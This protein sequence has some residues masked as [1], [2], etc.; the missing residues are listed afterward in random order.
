MATEKIWHLYIVRCGNNSLYTGITIDVAQR[1]A[2][3][4]AQGARC[5]KYLRGK[6]PLELV[7][8]EVVGT[9]SAASQ[10]EYAVKQLNKLQKEKLILT[11]EKKAAGRP[12]EN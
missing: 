4:L 3:H 7:Y 12:P 6:T 11:G 8:S 10:R 1:F 2:Q 9:K 5:A